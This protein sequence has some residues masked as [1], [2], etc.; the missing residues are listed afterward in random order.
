MA[1]ISLLGCNEWGWNI[2]TPNFIKMEVTS[3]PIFKLLGIRFP[4]LSDEFE[5]VR[6]MLD[7]KHAA[8]CNHLPLITEF[9]ESNKE[10]NFKIS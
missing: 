7:S 9:K 10:M 1:R 8:E 4:L 5:L 3:T 6:E 2:K